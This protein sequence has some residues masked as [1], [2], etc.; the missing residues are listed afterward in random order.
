MERNFFLVIL[1]KKM[2]TS[3]MA[4]SREDLTNNNNLGST[5]ANIPQFQFLEIQRNVFQPLLSGY[6]YFLSSSFPNVSLPTNRRMTDVVAYFHYDTII[7]N[8]NEDK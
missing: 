2:K 3:N 6:R 5:I 8:K 4:Y 7:S 1:K